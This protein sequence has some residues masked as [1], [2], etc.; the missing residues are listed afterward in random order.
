MTSILVLIEED[1]TAALERVKAD[2]GVVLTGPEGKDSAF[3]ISTY[4]Y[5]P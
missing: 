4:I 3:Y 1:L 5:M 2:V